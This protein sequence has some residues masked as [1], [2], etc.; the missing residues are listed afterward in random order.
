MRTLPKPPPLGH[1]GGGFVVTASRIMVGSG[2]NLGLAIHLRVGLDCIG[3][4]KEAVEIIL[5]RMETNMIVLV[6]R[7]YFVAIRDE[8]AVVSCGKMVVARMNKNIKPAG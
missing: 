1:K 2:Y 7:R 3:R 8:E 6:T 4:S 5:G